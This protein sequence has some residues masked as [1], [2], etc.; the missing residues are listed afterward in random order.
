MEDLLKELLSELELREEH[1]TI[2]K[3]ESSQYSR[4][5]KDKK[6]RVNE[7]NTASVLL[8]KMNKLFCAYCKGGHAHQDCTNVK[9]VDERRQLLRKYGRCFICAQKDHISRDCLSK[10]ACNICMAKH[11]VSICERGNSAPRNQFSSSHNSDRGCSVHSD[12]SSHAA[13]A[14]CN[15]QM[16]CNAMQILRQLEVLPFMWD[17]WGGSPYKPHKLWLGALERV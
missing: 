1:C 3:S 17:P 7:P 16:Q 5:D 12:S 2:N 13:A 14:Q 10:L 9:S 6:K 8:A 11:H 15:E 4:N